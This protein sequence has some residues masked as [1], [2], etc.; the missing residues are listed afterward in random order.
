MWKAATYR[1]INLFPKNVNIAKKKK[2]KTG[3][4]HGVGYQA[5]VQYLNVIRL[6]CII[7]EEMLPMLTNF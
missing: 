5:T 7:M 1:H 6:V 3:L 2:K 4:G